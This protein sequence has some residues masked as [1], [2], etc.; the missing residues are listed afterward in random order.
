MTNLK[1]LFLFSLLSAILVAIGWVIGGFGGM[2]VFL[3]I[4]AV[5]NFSS[6]WFSDKMVLKTSGAKE[7]TREEEPRLHSIVEEVA[8][9]AMIP[10]PR[11]Y[12]INSDTPNAFATGRNAKHAAVAVTTGIMRILDEREMRG[13]LGHELGHIRNHDILVQTVVATVAGAITMIAWMLQWSMIFGGGRRGGR[14]NPLALIGLLAT[15][16]LAPIAATLIRMAISRSRE[17]GADA[18]GARMVHDP[19]ALASALLKLQAG[20]QMRPLPQNGVTQA[21]AHLYIVNPFRSEGMATLF[22]TH[23]PIEERVRRLR[24]MA[25]LAI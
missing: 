25:G 23:P 20:V 4:A 2:V 14:D 16:I 3:V 10:K 9:L 17:F 8:N 12:L 21:T 13:V 1:T 11:V 19:E 6:Y 24:V 5:M 22:S 7:V 15:I 18:T